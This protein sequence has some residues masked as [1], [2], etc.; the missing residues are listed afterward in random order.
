MANPI[1]Q[2]FHQGQQ[3]FVDNPFGG[4][5]MAFL[6]GG[7]LMGAGG[8]V[9]KAALSI[10]AVSFATDLGLQLTIN[11]ISN[12]GDLLSAA[13]RVNLTSL[14]LSAA[15]PSA[16]RTS[17]MKNAAFSSAFEIKATD[18][19]NI[20]NGGKSFGDVA[21]SMALSAGANGLFQM[22]NRGMNYATSRGDYLLSKDFTP[23]SSAYQDLVF[24]V[25]VPSVIIRTTGF[26]G[27]FIGN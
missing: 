3:A 2:A 20:I 12:G 16:K 4:G 15:N 10:R 5:L 23:A 25:W 18:T 7:G 14:A 1:V 11:T 17:V 27:G 8:L 24:K 26:Y 9:G 13:Q 19:R 21:I 22:G 6:S